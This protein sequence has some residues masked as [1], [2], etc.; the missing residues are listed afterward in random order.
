MP[1]AKG[2]R[3]HI[4]N[5]DSK[6]KL[7]TARMC[8]YAQRATFALHFKGVDY[9]SIEVDMKNKPAELLDINPDGQVPAM[10][11]QGNPLYES[12]ICVEYIDETWESPS[13]LDL[14]PQDP[15]GRAK[16]RIWCDFI[17]KKI[18]T[19]FFC[20]RKEEERENAMQKLLNGFAKISQ[21]MSKSKGPYFAGPELSMVD[22]AF[23]PFI[24]RMVIAECFFNF[25]IPKTEKYTGFHTWWEAIQNHPSYIATKVDNGF[26]LEYA[27]NK[28]KSCATCS[29]SCASMK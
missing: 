28:L 1:K 8:P 24:N 22:V 13:G 2:R 20:M 14:M 26:L 21:E 16:Q 4:S 18:I 7:W 17:E 15:A 10:M 25:K 3:R 5:D 19:P 6:P 23:A 11:D 29:R 9:D 27:R 12:N